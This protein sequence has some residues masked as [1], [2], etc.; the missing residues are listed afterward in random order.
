VDHDGEPA[1]RRP[2]A[3]DLPII[4]ARPAGSG[5][6]GRHRVGDR[7][8]ADR[9]A[10]G[11]EEGRRRGLSMIGAG[12]G[13]GDAGCRQMSARVEK[14]LVGEVEHVVVGERHAA[15]IASLQR[16]ERD[17][18]VGAEIEGLP[19]RPFRLMLGDRPFEVAD[20]G[21]GGEHARADVAP[22]LG[23]RE[24]AEQLGGDVTSEEEVAG[25]AEP[26][27]PAVSWSR[28]LVHG[29]SLPAEPDLR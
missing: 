6:E 9:Y 25:E 22:H 10:A 11:G 19:P 13:K 7:D 28:R 24:A 17:R 12:A 14:A 3:P 5:G 27:R 16:V 23:R 2:T 1:E 26:H 4:G 8:E 20:H 15:E 29:P 18:R 21:V